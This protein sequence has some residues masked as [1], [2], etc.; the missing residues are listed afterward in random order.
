MSHHG[1]DFFVGVNSTMM[2]LDPDHYRTSDLYL[3]AYLLTSGAE[4]IRHDRA[5]ARVYFVFDCQSADL[6]SLR[7]QQPFRCD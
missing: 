2:K 6:E 4:M 3:A 5:G 1:G 7:R